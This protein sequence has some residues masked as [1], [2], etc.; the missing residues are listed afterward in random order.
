MEEREG[1][2]VQSGA[3]EPLKVTPVPA[4]AVIVFAIG[5]KRLLAVSPVVQ[6][7]EEHLVEPVRV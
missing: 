4:V 5:A 7:K 1:S 6:S 3:T 2:N